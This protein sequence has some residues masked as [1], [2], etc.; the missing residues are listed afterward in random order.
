[1]FI[2]GWDKDPARVTCYTI[3]IIL[4]FVIG[5][6]VNWLLKVYSTIFC[7]ILRS[8]NVSKGLTVYKHTN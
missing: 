5:Y 6:K 2:K 1:M 3:N 8:F 7:R 4:D